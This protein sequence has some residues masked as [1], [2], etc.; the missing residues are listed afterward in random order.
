MSEIRKFFK[1]RF[2]GGYIME[3]DFSQLEVVALAYLSQDPVLIHDIKS[4]VDLHIKSASAWL[5]K[6]ESEVTSAERK[7][8]KQMTFQLQYG[9]GP[10]SMA[11]KLGL[12]VEETRDFINTYYARYE[13]VKKWQ[14]DNIEAVNKSRVWDCVSRTK[15]NKPSGTG[16]LKACTGRRLTFKEYDAPEW[17]KDGFPQFS[18][19]EIKNHPVQSFATGDIVPHILGKIFRIIRGKNK[20]YG[21]ALMVMTVHD[22]IVFDVRR[23]VADDLERDVLAIMNNTVHYMKQDFGL[24]INVPITA[25]VTRGKDWSG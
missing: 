18:P 7:K 1:S 6:P 25:D 8:A 16:M 20:Y 5:G 15:T 12:R 23:D 11:E 2:S 21:R 13:G 10:K 17:V 19:T 24:D 22:S 9:A 3:F 14:D 4:G